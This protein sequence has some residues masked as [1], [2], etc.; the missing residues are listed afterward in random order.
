[1]PVDATRH[2]LEVI[3]AFTRSLMPGGQRAWLF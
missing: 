3:S 1:M 2:Q